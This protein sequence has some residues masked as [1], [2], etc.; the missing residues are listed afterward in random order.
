MRAATT[1]GD[2][3][4]D[5]LGRIAVSQNTRQKNNM[6]SPAATGPTLSPNCVLISTIFTSLS[7]CYVD[8]GTECSIATLNTYLPS[9]SQISSSLT[10]AEMYSACNFHYVSGTGYVQ[11]PGYNPN[12][13]L[14][15]DGSVTP[16][17]LVTVYPISVIYTAMTQFYSAHSTKQIYLH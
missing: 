7:E 9:G 6:A 15:P 4:Y 16:A 11:D 3:W 12:G 13:K 5:R 1:P 2:F 10:L 17:V 8:G 14:C